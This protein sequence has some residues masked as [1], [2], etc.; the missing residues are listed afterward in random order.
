MKHA[1]LLSLMILIP[2][3]SYAQAAPELTTVVQN[4]ENEN[5]LADS[6]SKTLYVFDV[7]QGSGTS[8]CTGDCAE[9][10]P[11]YV[12]TSEEAATL[13]APLGSVARQNGSLQLT[14]NDRPVYTYIF[15]RVKGDEKGDGLG[16]VWHYIEMK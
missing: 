11:P 6:F 14:H 1:L 16:G 10:W 15:D 12:L 9:V 2:N 13:Q 7:D 8:N 5:L 3:L 4:D